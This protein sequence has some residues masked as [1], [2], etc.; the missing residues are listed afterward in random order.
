MST[1]AEILKLP[2]SENFK[3]FINVISEVFFTV[4]ATKESTVTLVKSSP[5]GQKIHVIK[6]FWCYQSVVHKPVPQMFGYNC[7]EDSVEIE[8]P[9]L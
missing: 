4:T 9:E 6:A 7:S 3:F 2:L 1:L 5:L 8:W